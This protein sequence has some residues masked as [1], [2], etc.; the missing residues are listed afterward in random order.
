MQIIQPLKTAYVVFSS[1]AAAKMV[2]DMLQGQMCLNQKDRIDIEFTPSTLNYKMATVTANS[3][4][5]EKPPPP[6]GSGS[7]AMSAA[8]VAA[9]ASYFNPDTGTYGGSNYEATVHE[10]W[11]CE[12]VRPTCLTRSATARTS[13]GARAASNANA[14]RPT[15]AALFPSSSR[16]PPEVDTKETLSLQRLPLRQLQLVP[17]WLRPRPR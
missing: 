11:I 13:A 6:R 1:V 4:N 10:D 17:T 9:A 14:T 3:R 7:N 2:L 15:T 16:R 5:S 8:A 12:Y